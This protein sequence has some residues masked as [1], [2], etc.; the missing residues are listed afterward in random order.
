MTPRERGTPDKYVQTFFFLGGGKRGG[1]TG[2]N[3]NHV[4]FF[5]FIFRKLIMS[6]LELPESSLRLFAIEVDN[7]F[8]DRKIFV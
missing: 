1:G 3:F 8:L 7:Q 5:L 4:N 2:S 6:C